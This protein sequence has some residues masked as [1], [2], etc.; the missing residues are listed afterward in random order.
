MNFQINMEILIGKD[1]HDKYYY[2]HFFTP[3]R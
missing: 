2:T 1:K 3:N